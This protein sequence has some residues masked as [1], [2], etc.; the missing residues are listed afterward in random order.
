MSDKSNALMFGHDLWQRVFA[1]V[2]TEY[3]E[4]EASH[5]YVD[6]LA[7]E[8]VRDPS[9]FDVIVTCNLFGDILSDLG[10]ALV[11]GLGLTPSA[12]INPEGISLFEPVHGSA[13]KLTGQNAANPFAAILSVAMMFQHFGWQQAAGTV[14]NAV[15]AAI[16]EGRM[17]RD[18]G[19]SM[20]T[21][22]TGEWLADYITRSGR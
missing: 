19:G 14:E 2:R 15:R 12:N 1:A 11:G 18:L 4:I 8:M 10:A 16:R 20:G 13:P 21:R 6:T 3:P 7:M 9:Q 22:E 5:L 17:T